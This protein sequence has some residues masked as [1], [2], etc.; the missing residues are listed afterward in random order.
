VEA[1]KELGL[2]Y[3]QIIKAFSK[4]DTG[5]REE[6]LDILEREFKQLEKVLNYMVKIR[7]LE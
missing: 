3:R 4:A 6:M 1:K 2:K 7:A 5:K